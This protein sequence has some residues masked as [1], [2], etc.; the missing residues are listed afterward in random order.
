MSS[1]PYVRIDRADGIGSIEFFHP[2]SNSMPGAQLQR[3][4]E[5]FDELGADPSVR[6]V[7]LR[8]AGERAFCGGASFDELTAIADEA[9]GLAFFSGFARV[10]LAMRR[11]PKFVVALVQGRC[12][13]GGVG[14]AASAD[15]CLALQSASV[16]LSELAVGIG[17]FVVGPA[18]E[19]KVGV[20]GFSELA[21]DAASW[22]D[23]EWARNRGLFNALVATR[24]ELETETERLTRSLNQSNPEAMSA[25]KQ[26]LWFGTNHWETLLYERAAISGRLVLSDFTR[27]AIA[28]FKAS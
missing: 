14:L 20:S 23:A 27:Q 11:C 24:D 4:A 12:V 8:S 5:A 15:Y 19:R 18:V 26:A 13:G 3:L 17:P 6:V 10:I 16:K 21:I 25:L 7:V 22:R 9:Q 1:E 28:R 2:Q